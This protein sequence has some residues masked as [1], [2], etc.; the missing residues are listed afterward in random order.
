MR[1]NVFLVMAGLGLGVL[2]AGPAHAAATTNG[3]AAAGTGANLASGGAT[4]PQPPAPR[5]RRFAIS[6]GSVVQGASAKIVLRVDG[7]TRSVRTRVEILPAGSRRAVA[8][9][10]L[11]DEPTGKVVE[12][13]W[14]QR[15]PLAPGRYVA[16][17]HAVDGNGR[18]LRRS[19][20][21]PGRTPLQVVA[22]PAPPV[23]PPPPPPP[24][25]SAAVGSGRF[26]IQGPYSFGGAD[27]RFGAGRSGHSHQG[28][29]MTAAEGTP[30]VSPRA[31]VVHWRAYQASGA[32][33]YLVIRADDGR[34]LVFMHLREG[35]LLVS[36][37]QAV[38]AGQRIA[39]VGNTGRS[40]GAHLHFEI[41][42]NG[43]WAEGSK[44]ID[45]LPQLQAWAAGGS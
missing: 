14:R 22:K 39:D 4:H 13:P 23:A 27:A 44:P 41:W 37:G 34:D 28:Q 19:A 35:S 24:P 3:G 32:G 6:P 38:T 26:P 20:S 21:A 17:L 36:K 31:G 45:P 29:D 43:W 11:G 40:D 10:K 42:P 16:R 5:V 30:V 7:V 25:P 1:R 15:R 9:I 8:R 2:P 12:Y 18:R 33:H